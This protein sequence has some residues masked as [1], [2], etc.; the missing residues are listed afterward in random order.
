MRAV[1]RNPCLLNRECSRWNNN[2]S[3][4]YR[5]QDWQISRWDRESESC[6][7]VRFGNVC[8]RWRGR[9]SVCPSAWSVRY[10]RWRMSRCYSLP[11]TTWSAVRTV[12]QIFPKKSVQFV[13]QKFRV[14][15]RCSLLEPY[16]KLFCEYHYICQRVLL[17]AA[18]CLKF[19]FASNIIL[20][21]L[22]CTVIIKFNEW[23]KIVAGIFWICYFIITSLML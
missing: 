15:S 10:V 22:W 3:K 14:Q 6:S 17:A 12:S 5:M 21:F 13:W 23:K 19:H 9:T 2:T 7:R 4:P 8:V 16:L 18:T 11:V 1:R 20:L